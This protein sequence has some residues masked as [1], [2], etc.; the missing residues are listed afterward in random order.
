MHRSVEGLEAPGE[1]IRHFIERSLRRRISEAGG[2][3]ARDRQAF[4]KEECFEAVQP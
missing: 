2:C 1:R 4:A 3:E